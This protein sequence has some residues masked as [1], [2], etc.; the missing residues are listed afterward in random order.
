[1]S[2]EMLYNGSMKA[3]LVRHIIQSTKGLLETIPCWSPHGEGCPGYF[4]SLTPN[5][6][7]KAYILV[8]SD[9]F[10]RLTKSYPLATIEASTMAHTCECQFISKFGVLRQVHTDQGTQFE[11]DLF[12]EICRLDIIKQGQ[13]LATPIVMVL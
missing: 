1:M 13:F 2:R 11:S 4:W 7:M 3:L 12:I 9:Y 5:E 6:F 8:I 10:T